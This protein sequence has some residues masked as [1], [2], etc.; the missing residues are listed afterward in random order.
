MADK[1]INNCDWLQS[2]TDRVSEAERPV[3]EGAWETL[4]FRLQ[5]QASQAGKSGRHKRGMIAAAAAL[6]GV[7]LG[8]AVYLS[9]GTDVSADKSTAIS[10][11][12]NISSVAHTTSITASDT[13][14]SD[15]SAQEFRGVST[16]KP[17]AS[18]GFIASTDSEPEPWNIARFA[19][20]AN[21]ALPSEDAP[22]NLPNLSADEPQKSADNART[23]PQETES[24]SATT[25]ASTQT[26]VL[27][28]IDIKSR[29]R[30]TLTISAYGNGVIL[31][32]RSG[33]AST[34]RRMFIPAEGGTSYAAPRVVKYKYSHK[35][36]INFGVNVSKEVAK[37][38]SIGTGLNYSLLISDV[39][40]S[41][42]I[43][44]EKLRQKVQFIG[45][46]FN[47]KWRFWRWNRMSA[48]VGG[49]LQIE[50][51]IS[52]KFNGE[53]ISAKRIQWSVHGLAGFQY[54][55]SDK[56]GFYI[57]PK[58]S[59]YMTDFPLTTIRNEHP[60]NLNLQLGL[61]INF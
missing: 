3:P 19:P 60:I 31:A 34:T 57:E 37:N 30:N 1:N 4:R 6:A 28:P 7:I 39:Y 23:E 27:T 10:A 26:S 42:D 61:S 46:P 20:T 2:L 22:K 9:L 15:N 48:Y 35:I 50:R 53:D 59:H 18:Y 54:N 29:I 56:V 16:A 24:V 58:V 21:D 36:P 13:G 49:E 43:K 41:S 55:V 32:D 11:T 25:H 12:R 14:P 52:A 17:R 51:C 40:S 45:I 44:G 33:T 5:D 8:T 38:I 47:V